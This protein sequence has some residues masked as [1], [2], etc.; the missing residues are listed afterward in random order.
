MRRC[1]LR[2]Q[3][4]H[5]MLVSMGQNFRFIQVYM[6]IRSAERAKIS[7]TIVRGGHPATQEA[8]IYGQFQWRNLCF[9]SFYPDSQEASHRR[10]GR[11]NDDERQNMPARCDNM[12][13]D[14]VA[15]EEANSS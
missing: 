15:A 12:I 13:I 11:S 1:A 10:P 7:K 5:L 6:R 9:Y 3:T 4:E 2:S 14:R 8:R